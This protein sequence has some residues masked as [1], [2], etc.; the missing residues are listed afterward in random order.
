MKIQID[1]LALKDGTKK[2]LLSA[3][4]FFVHKLRMYRSYF[5]PFYVFKQTQSGLN[6]K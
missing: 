2:K 3:G 1:G 5:N 6:Q 4:I